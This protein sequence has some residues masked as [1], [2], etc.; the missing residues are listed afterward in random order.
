MRKI[1]FAS[2]VAVFL[3]TFFGTQDI[4]AR[5]IRGILLDGDNNKAIEVAVI[6]LQEMDSIVFISSTVAEGGGFMV[7]DRENRASKVMIKA[8][9]YDTVELDIPFGRNDH[10]MGSIYIFHRFKELGE[11]TV[12]AS[13]M[14]VAV[15][16]MTVYP[17]KS[18][19]R[20]SDSSFGVL[21]NLMLPGLEI[22]PVTRTATINGLPV[23]YKINGI[24]RSAARIAALNPS[25]IR[26]IEYSN[27][28]S[29]RETTDNVGGVINIFLREVNS[30]GSLYERAFSAVTTKMADN[31]FSIRH[32][33]RASEFCISYG[34]QW[35]DYNESY[36]D[37]RI[38]YLAGG[39]P[40]I[41][42][43]KGKAGKLRMTR[44][45]IRASYVFT[46][47]SRTLFSATAGYYFGPWK[48]VTQESNTS[49][50]DIGKTEY[51]SERLIDQ[52]YSMPSID[53]YLKQTFGDGSSLEVNAVGTYNHSDNSQDRLIEYP[54]QETQR[55]DNSIASSKWSA[56]GEAVWSRR[57]RKI[58]LR[59]G[60]REFYQHAENIYEISAG[61]DSR[62]IL[63][64]NCLFVY[65]DVQGKIRKFGYTLGTGL[66][67][68]RNDNGIG[69]RTEYVRNYSVG[70][71]MMS[72]LGG[73]TL[74]GAVKYSPRT[75][76]LGE[77]GDAL[78]R[79]DD[80]TASI[81]NPL[82]RSSESLEADATV[83]YRFREMS[84]NVRGYYG[85]TWNPVYTLV[86]YEDGLYVTQPVNGRG[87]DAWN[88]GLNASYRH[89]N[90][91]SLS[92]GASLY[93]QTAGQHCRISE[94]DGM[95][96]AGV[97]VS[98][99]LF[100]QWNGLSFNA[101][102]KSRS[103][104]LYGE[105]MTT[106]GEEMN[107]SVSYAWR[108]FNFSVIG[109]WIGVR[110]GD[111]KT[112]ESLSAINPYES[113]NMLRDNYNTVGISVAYRLDYGRQKKRDSRSLNN[114]DREKGVTQVE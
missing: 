85:H 69:D 59:T 40:I 35:R 57:L 47:S 109:V 63:D 39:T 10:D 11:L 88:V 33:H 31:D 53:F 110:R 80:L 46:P 42:T 60:I 54:G 72:P 82:L 114:S 4:C 104:A 41:R 28:P 100:V 98:G 70:R 51:D 77:L 29:I 93:F 102:A 5:K 96:H 43:L 3:A 7:D 52:P 84:F 30:G 105:V 15:D 89:I 20:S 74:N 66:F 2:V 111:Y 8:S 87:Y 45:D 48:R 32:N 16:K 113:T 79:T 50:D 94:T 81:G 44:N 71:W 19:L 24:P 14:T 22:N 13:V 75:P 108:N 95:S 65:A 21:A 78:L 62:D 68:V 38:S 55:Y 37:S 56:I 106:V 25:D 61:G 64:N 36:T 112:F 83:M 27:S 18:V 67:H 76:S 9:G 12:N 34:M 6:E 49:R 26:K 73:F 103:K 86:Y 91:T 90:N 92:Y 97:Y 99:N 58:L 23:I 1:L 101:S 17:E 107:V